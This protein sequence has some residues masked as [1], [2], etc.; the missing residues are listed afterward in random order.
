[1]Y[2]LLVKGFYPNRLGHIA[3]SDQVI[4]QQLA[5]LGPISKAEV[6][7][8]LIVI[9]MAFCWILREPLKL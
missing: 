2:F 3:G 9:F 5:E 7:V 1:M 8:S 4:R 6:R